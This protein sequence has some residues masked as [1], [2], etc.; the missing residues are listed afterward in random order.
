LLAAPNAH[1]PAYHPCLYINRL[2]FTAICP[3]FSSVNGKQ[4]T[5]AHIGFGSNCFIQLNKSAQNG[6]PE[7]L[8][9]LKKRIAFFPHNGD[10]K[11]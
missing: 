10:E 4:K 1:N 3:A 5:K 7:A 6:T 9:F 8:F 11:T 2:D